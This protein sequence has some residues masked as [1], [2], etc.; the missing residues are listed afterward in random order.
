MSS[1][2]PLAGSVAALIVVGPPP[3]VRT[4][5]PSYGEPAILAAAARN[6]TA[7]TEA[8]SSLT[9]WEH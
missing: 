5:L 9:R 8:A 3:M 4:D 2:V 1:T 7:F 6:L